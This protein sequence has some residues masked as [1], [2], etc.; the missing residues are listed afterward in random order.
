MCQS[1]CWDLRNEYKSLFVY[2]WAGLDLKHSWFAFWTPIRNRWNGDSDSVYG[3]YMV[4]NLNT[5]A[6][7]AKWIRGG[8]SVSMNKHGV[9]WRWSG[10]TAGGHTQVGTTMHGPV[11]T[12]LRLLHLGDRL[13][14]ASIIHW[15]TCLPPPPR[16]SSSREGAMILVIFMPQPIDQYLAHS[17]GHSLDQNCPWGPC[18]KVLVLTQ[19]LWEVVDPLTSEACGKCPSHWWRR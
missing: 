9:L 14:F 10:D 2:H 13:S 4:S 3:L 15:H 6:G 8:S 19:V 16:L 1:F 5:K 12:H 11:S 18:V 7:V 17:S